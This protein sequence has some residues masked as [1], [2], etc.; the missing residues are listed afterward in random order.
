M[1]QALGHVTSIRWSGGFSNGSRTFR[2]DPLGQV[3]SEVHDGPQAP[4]RIA[5]RTPREKAERVVSAAALNDRRP[6]SCSSARVKRVGLVAVP[7][8]AQHVGALHGRLHTKG[9]PII[10]AHPNTRCRHAHAVHQVPM[11][12]REEARPPHAASTWTTRHAS[13]RR[14]RCRQSSRRL[15]TVVPL[16][17]TT[18]NGRRPKFASRRMAWSSAEGSIR[19]AIG[20]HLGEVHTT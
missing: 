15:A 2:S 7:G 11:G 19:P 12:G 17:A 20:V 18:H 16:V 10:C 14:R 1:R 5:A 8:S 9:R 6:R 3:S 4:T 13:R